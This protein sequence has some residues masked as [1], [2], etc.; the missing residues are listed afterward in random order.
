MKMSFFF[1]MPPFSRA[2]QV[3]FFKLVLL[4]YFLQS[5][6]VMQRQELEIKVFVVHAMLLQLQMPF[7]LKDT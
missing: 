3:E 7:H 1:T 6:I 5:I 4:Q 2:E